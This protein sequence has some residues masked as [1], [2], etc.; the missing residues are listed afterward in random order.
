MALPKLNLVVLEKMEPRRHGARFMLIV[1]A[2]NFLV[3]DWSRRLAIN[4]DE[5]KG[6]PA[7]ASDGGSV[8]KVVTMAT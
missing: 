6:C 7:L 4:R 5:L 1:S 3:V 2:A 8:V